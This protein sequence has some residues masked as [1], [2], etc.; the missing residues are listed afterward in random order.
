[1]RYLYFSSKTCSPCKQLAPIMERVNQQ[2]IRVQKID[3]DDEYET[4]SEWGIRN[5]PTVVLVTDSGFE[6]SRT[7]GVKPE[8]F[9]IE[10]YKRNLA[11]Q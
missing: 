8:S 6:M 2:G 1:M 10:L 5:V 4:T 11:K 9:Y 3:V 7:V